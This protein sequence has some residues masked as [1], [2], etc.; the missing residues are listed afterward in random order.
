MKNA[1]KWATGVYDT[2]NGD[3]FCHGGII[4]WRD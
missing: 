1:N 3:I 4:K 2:K